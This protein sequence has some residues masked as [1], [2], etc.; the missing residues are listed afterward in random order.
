[1]NKI[2]FLSVVLIIAELFIIIKP[3]GLISQNRAG[4]TQKKKVDILPKKKI[5]ISSGKDFNEDIIPEDIKSIIDKE[6][7]RV[8]AELYKK[9]KNSRLS[10]KTKDNISPAKTNKGKIPSLKNSALKNKK[11]KY[12]LFIE[13]GDKIARL[14]REHYARA[15][16][17]DR[18]KNIKLADAYFFRAYKAYKKAYKYCRN[19]TQKE[20]VGERMRRMK[21]GHYNCSKILMV[22]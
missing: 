1:M 13:Q 7:D 22:P 2:I 3:L 17:R 15:F 19:K 18:R 10:V 14:G 12:S 16:K 8:R 21:K 6:C 9:F 20:T 5:N 11:D 4:S